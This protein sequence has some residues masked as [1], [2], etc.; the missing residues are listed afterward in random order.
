MDRY[1][2]LFPLFLLLIAV[3]LFGIS[4]HEKIESNPVGVSFTGVDISALLEEVPVFTRPDVSAPVVVK[5][6]PKDTVWF[7]GKTSENQFEKNING[8]TL[9]DPF[10]KIQGQGLEG[11]VYGGDMDFNSVKDHPQ[12]REWRDKRYAGFFP[13]EWIF[14]LDFSQKVSAIET[15]SMFGQ[16]YNAINLK[17][18]ALETR[19]NENLELPLSA[20]GPSLDWIADLLYPIDLMVD[21]KEGDIQLLWDY[22]RFSEISRQTIGNRDVIFAGINQLLFPFDSME[23]WLVQ[24]HLELAGGEVLSTLGDADHLKIL[25]KIDLLWNDPGPFEKP[26]WQIKNALLDDIL[27][28]KTKFWNDSRL[29]GRE[30]DY[31]ISADLECLSPE[32]LASLKTRRMHFQN[33]RKHKIQHNHKESISLKDL[34]R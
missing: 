22:N 1:R 15:D 9:N 25:K 23:C 31:I 32:E 29:M 2:H 33:P 30:L 3:S 12:C 4:C 8:L 5:L 16:L 13:H 20:N 14:L 26:L 19:I 27:N 6:S 17:R 11:W 24:Y 18:E 7:S 34:S 28:E 21:P 10:L